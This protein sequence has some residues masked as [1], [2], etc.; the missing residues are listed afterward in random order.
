MFRCCDCGAAF[1]P[2]DAATHNEIHRIDG[3]NYIEPWAA[4]PE[5]GSTDLEQVETCKIC[6]DW[7]RRGACSYCR[8]AIRTV[9]T[10][11]IDLANTADGKE[12]VLDEI[13]EFVEDYEIDY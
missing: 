9:L 11:L 7:A 8:K 4:C 5:C 1:A 3:R 13:Q 6:G 2:E 12:A 10:H